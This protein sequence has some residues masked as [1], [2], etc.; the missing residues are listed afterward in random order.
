MFKRVYH[1]KMTQKYG[2]NLYWVRIKTLLIRNNC[3]K[4]DRMKKL[5]RINF[6]IFFAM[7]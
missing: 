4:H 7:V 2:L 6:N 3:T 1:L 5:K